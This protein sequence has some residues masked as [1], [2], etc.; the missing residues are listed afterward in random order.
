MLKADK[1]QLRFSYCILTVI[2]HSSQ[3]QE[4]MDYLLLAIFRG[5]A[6]CSSRS[7]IQVIGLSI[8]ITSEI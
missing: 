8:G 7:Q 4:V 1:F 5:R 6:E 2:N 3:P